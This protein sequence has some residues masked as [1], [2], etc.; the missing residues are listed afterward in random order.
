MDDNIKRIL[1]TA[2]ELER[3]QVK[4]DLAPAIESV[5]HIQGFCHALRALG[6]MT[7][8]ESFKTVS[9]FAWNVEQLKKGKNG[10][11]VSA[12]P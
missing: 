4:L 1:D 11:V 6:L 9:E 3:G 5:C 10:R 7:V 2:I 12:R 8:E